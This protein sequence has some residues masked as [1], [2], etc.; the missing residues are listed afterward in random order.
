MR[1]ELRSDT[2][3]LP[4]KGMREAMAVADVGDDVFG[5][6][7]SVNSLEQLASMLGTEA[8][9]LPHTATMCNQIAMKVHTRP[10]DEI[11]C[12]RLACL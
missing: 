11:I 10:M 12:D 7:P 4:S 2:F 3:T 1:I 9:L 6:D 8:A 5:E